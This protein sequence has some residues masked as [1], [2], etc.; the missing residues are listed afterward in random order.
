MA[1]DQLADKDPYVFTGHFFFRNPASSHQAGAKSPPLPSMGT[2]HLI[3]VGDKIVHIHQGAFVL[4]P[5]V[6]VLVNIC[7]IYASFKSAH[8]CAVRQHYIECV[9]E[10]P[11]SLIFLGFSCAWMSVRL[12]MRHTPLSSPCFRVSLAGSTSC[13]R[14]FSAEFGSGGSQ[15]PSCKLVEVNL[16]CSNFASWSYGEASI[17][18]TVET[19]LQPIKRYNEET[20]S[21][22]GG[23]M[24]RRGAKLLIWSLRGSFCMTSWM[25]S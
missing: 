23:T 10:M 25:A 11:G 2:V 1:S 19:L 3:D 4:D 21:R 6:G 20:L 18:A 14:T 5:A 13:L 12:T 16:C 17:P 24:Q 8:L 7:R 22:L 15:K 9:G